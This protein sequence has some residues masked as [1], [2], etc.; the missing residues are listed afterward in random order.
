MHIVL[1]G[2]DDKAARDLL[3]ACLSPAYEFIDTGEP[4]QAL[5]LA[6]E[7]KPQRLQLIEKYG[8]HGETR[9]PGL[10][11]VKAAFRR[12]SFTLTALTASL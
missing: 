11:R 1:I 4:E 3:G 7:A 10:F 2:D 6:L 9:T 12:N 5:A 8:R